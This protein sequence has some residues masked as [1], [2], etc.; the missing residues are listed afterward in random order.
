MKN[1]EALLK[2]LQNILSEPQTE[3]K[4]VQYPAKFLTIDHKSGSW[5]LVDRTTKEA[6]LL[7]KD[8]KVVTGQVLLQSKIFTSAGLLRAI[9]QIVLPSER[10]NML[11]LISGE[12]WS[13]KVEALNDGDVVINSWLVPVVIDGSY[14]K[15]IWEIKRTALKA[16]INFIQENNLKNLNGLMLK[17]SLINRKEGGMKKWSEPKIVEYSNITEV[18]D[19]KLLQTL[20]DFTREFQEFRKNYNLQAIQNEDLS[21]VSE[22]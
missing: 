9:S 11:D 17:L 16:V 4:T 7:Q 8:I 22:L 10:K 2:E 13:E 6:T 12:L 5:Q 19:E 3:R 14:T 1:L 21:D 15:A 20:L 18:K